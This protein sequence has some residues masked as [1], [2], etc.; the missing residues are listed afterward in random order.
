MPI[1]VCQ[2]THRVVRNSAEVRISRLG[3]DR[4]SC[5][6]SPSPKLPNKP[7]KQGYPTFFSSLSNHSLMPASCAISASSCSSRNRQ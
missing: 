6:Q 5:F 2:H 7:L 3:G 4:L 1:N